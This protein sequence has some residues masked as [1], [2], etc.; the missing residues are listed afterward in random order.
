MNDTFT[1]SLQSLRGIDTL[2]K[3]YEDDE[4]L[5]ITF[6]F[7]LQFLKFK[8]FLYNKLG[9][10]PRMKDY[11]SVVFLQNENMKEH[12]YNIFSSCKVDE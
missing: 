4:S 5:M 6:A 11:F 12:H 10:Y 8:D 9:E 2:S 7:A 1:S 3:C